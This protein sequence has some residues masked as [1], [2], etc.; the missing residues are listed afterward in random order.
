MYDFNIS[1]FVFLIRNIV[2]ILYV[3]LNILFG[4]LSLL[5]IVSGYVDKILFFIKRYLKRGDV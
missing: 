5:F 1:L 3:N 4:V 2:L